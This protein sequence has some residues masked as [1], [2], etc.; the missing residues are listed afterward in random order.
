MPSLTEAQ[1]TT[2]DYVYETLMPRLG[3]SLYAPGDDVVYESKDGNDEW[4]IRS[5]W[6]DPESEDPTRLPLLEVVATCVTMGNGKWKSKHYW[7]YR[8]KTG[9]DN[10]PEYKGWRVHAWV[11]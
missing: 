1:K 3:V 4:R 7:F 11:G 10:H 9:C 2:C 5:H 8:P 6:F